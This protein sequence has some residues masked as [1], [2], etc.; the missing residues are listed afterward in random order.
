MSLEAEAES[1]D[2]TN[3]QHKA[4]LIREHLKKKKV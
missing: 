4:D 2:Y 1:Y 3:R